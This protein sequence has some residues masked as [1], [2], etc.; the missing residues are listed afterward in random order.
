MRFVIAT[1]QHSLIFEQPTPRSY[2]DSE[3]SKRLVQAVHAY[4]L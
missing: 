3:L 1:A 4:L 2:S